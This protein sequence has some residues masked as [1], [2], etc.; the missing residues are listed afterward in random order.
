[1]LSVLAVLALLI[2]WIVSS[3]GGGGKNGADGSNGKHPTLDDQPGTVRFRPCDQSSAGRTRRVD[4]RWGHR[5]RVGFGL[6]VG[7]D[8]GFR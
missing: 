5:R 1:M 6:G 4:D 3:G 8:L 2:A 7:L